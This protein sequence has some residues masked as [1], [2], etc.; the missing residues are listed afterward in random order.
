[1]IGAGRMGAAIAAR[2]RASGAEVVIFNR[3]RERAEQ[4]GAVCGAAV[5]D[6]AAAATAAAPVVLVSLADDQA[7]VSAY[8]GADGIAAGAGPGTLVVETSTIDPL[9]VVRLAAVLDGTGAGFLDGPVS[10][11]VPL[12][13]R[14]ELTVMAGGRAADLDR[15][16]DVFDVLAKRVIHV[17]RLGAGATIKLAVN[18]IVHATNQA[19]AE[20]L[21][22]AEK[23]GVQ[24]AAAYEVFASSAITSP[25]L[26]YKR[27]A[28]EHPGDAAITFSLDLVAK[29][30]A[31]ILGLADRVGA[32]MEQ[33]A[34]G[35]RTV[36]RAVA[37]GLGGADMSA[38][39]EVFRRAP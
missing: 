15:A 7:C 9:T 13:E 12:V 36:A 34:T 30:Y 25:F 10:G 6:S 21:V 24:R 17:G 16:R 11:S 23:A 8:D 39:A 37:A 27:N 31:L 5:A 33:A 20:A 1:M 26:V 2:L 28:F 32:V 22:L 38:I 29:D 4:V 35:Q 3:T 14:G 18:G 19:L